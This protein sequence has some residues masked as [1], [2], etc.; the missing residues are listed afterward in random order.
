MKSNLLVIVAL[1]CGVVINV[2]AQ[3][4]DKLKSGLRYYIDSKDS[5]HYISLS[6]TG[7]FWA[8]STQ[9]NPYTI[10]QGTPQSNTADFSV[11]RIRFVLGGVLT[12]RVSFFI[13]F[14]QNSLNLFIST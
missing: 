14:G 13:Q 4:S 5:S 6:M 7:Q 1:L 10:V 12:D 11:R 9:N 2:N 8:R 3:F